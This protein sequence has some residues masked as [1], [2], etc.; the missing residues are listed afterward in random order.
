MRTHDTVMI[1]QDPITK[2]RPEG[3]AVLLRHIDNYPDGIEVWT[4]L[5]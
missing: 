2:Q 3:K 1:Y 4:V 5:V